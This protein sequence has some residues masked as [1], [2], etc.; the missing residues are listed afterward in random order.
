MSENQKERLVEILLAKVEG[1]SQ[2]AATA[3]EVEAL[4]AV[5]QVLV[6]LFRD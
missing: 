2:N 4:A 3:E 1:F 6:E 5:A